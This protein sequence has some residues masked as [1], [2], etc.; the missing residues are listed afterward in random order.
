MRLSEG[1]KEDDLKRFAAQ[2][3]KAITQNGQS[4]ITGLFSGGICDGWQ[5]GYN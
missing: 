2:L 1:A 3:E 5:R 4:T